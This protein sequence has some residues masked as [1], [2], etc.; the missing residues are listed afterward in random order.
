MV[1]ADV[2]IGCE[3]TMTRTL[4]D[5]DPSSRCAGGPLPYSL[6]L[7][8]RLWCSP[9]GAECGRC[10]TVWRSS[11]PTGSSLATACEGTPDSWSGGRV[12]AGFPWSC[13]RRRARFGHPACARRVVVFWQMGGSPPEVGG[14]PSIWREMSSASEWQRSSGSARLLAWRTLV[15]PTKAGRSELKNRHGVV[16]GRTRSNAAYSVNPGP[17]AIATM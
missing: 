16:V 7:T 6:E 2:A 13:H 11:S 15:A 12:H 9:S 4:C 5:H 10:P 3:L 14:C 8:A 17:N 1:G